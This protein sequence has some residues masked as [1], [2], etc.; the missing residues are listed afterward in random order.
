MMM[1]RNTDDDDEEEL[2]SGRNGKLGEMNGRGGRWWRRRVKTRFADESLPVKDRW[3]WY[4]VEWH[5]QPL[6]NYAMRVKGPKIIAT[7]CSHFLC[8]CMSGGKLVNDNSEAVINHCPSQKR[9]EDLNE[10]V[11]SKQ[12]VWLC[13][14]PTD[15]IRK[16]YLNLKYSVWCKNIHAWL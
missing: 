10:F 4:H 9:K 7:I 3:R 14:K 6:Y 8:A 5:I 2:G 16:V 12:S 15:I 13:I 11:A 1:K